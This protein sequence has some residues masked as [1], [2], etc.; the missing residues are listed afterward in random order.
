VDLEDSKLALARKAGAAHTINSKTESLPERLQALTN[1]DGAN[2]AIEAVG[3]PATFLAAVE[4]AAYAG[5]VVY[6]GYVKALVLYETKYFV[7]KELDIRGS[8]NSSAEDFRAVIAMLESGVYPVAETI[9]RTVSFAEAG[10]ALQDWADNPAVITKIHV[11][12]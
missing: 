7:L 5:R 8:R 1:G 6:L 2:V 10:Q 12:I 4:S 3:V 9:T 11:E